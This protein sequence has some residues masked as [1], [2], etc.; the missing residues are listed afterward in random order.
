M[1]KSGNMTTK[2]VAVLAASMMLITVSV[3]VAY[4]A[5]VCAQDLDSDRDVS[6]N[7]SIS[8]TN[9]HNVGINNGTIWSN[10]NSITTNFGLVT[11]NTSTGTITTNYGNDVDPTFNTITEGVRYNYGGI[12]D[13]AGRVSD[14]RGGNIQ[15]NLSTGYVGPNSGIIT[16]NY[17]YI[18]SNIYNSNIHSQ[19]YIETNHENATV[20]IN[21]SHVGTN[22]GLIEN[23]EAWPSFGSEYTGTVDSNHGRVRLNESTVTNEDDG[24]VEINSQSGTV[25]G[26]GTIIDNYGSVT[27]NASITNYYSGTLAQNATITITNN[28][29]NNDSITATNRYYAVT[30][31]GFNDSEAECTNG[32]SVKNSTNYL[33]STG[34]EGTITITPNEGYEINGNTGTDLNGT[35]FRYSLVRDGNNV[36]VTLSSPTGAVTINPA[37]LNLL[38]TAIGQGS[39][40]VVVRTDSSVTVTEDETRSNSAATGT[41]PTAGNAITAAQISAM[42]ESALAANPGATVLDL[43]LGND[44]SFTADTLIALCEKNSV[45]KNCHFTHN[46]EKFVLFIPVIDP[47]SAAYQ[48]CKALLDAEEGKQA[49]PI[50]LSYLFAPVKFS[51]SQE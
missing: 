19:G 45:A 3:P 38:I 46:G 39:G 15:N 50:R 34:A 2:V 22:N 12:T 33:K 24:I 6:R 26:T 40:N 20:L 17:G 48:Q 18:Y 25:S 16:N 27:G 13:N 29:S 23:N 8:S 31:T 43:D 42:I 14:N 37:A 4:P 51:L 44:P 1:R 32:F 47:T 49:G 36:I 9:G 28:Y 5:V 7:E 41:V 35:N 10:E 11:E 30:I 21:V